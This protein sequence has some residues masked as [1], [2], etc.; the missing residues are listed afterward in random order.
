MARPRKEYDKKQFEDLVTMGFNATGVARFFHGTENEVNEWC[1]ARYGQTFDELCKEV[2]YATRPNQDK[3]RPYT[4]YM[5]I[6]PN[7]K[8]YIGITRQTLKRRWSNGHG[9]WSNDHFTSAI[10][11][12]GWNNIE[13][14][15]LYMRLTKEEAEKTEVELIK[16]F[17]TT[18]RRYGYNKEGGGS[19]NKEVSA[20]TREKL[21]EKSTGV[22]ASEE[23]RRK[24]SESH[25]GEK[26]H[27]YGVP[28]TEEMKEHLRELRS[29][30]VVQMD[31][32]GNIIS[33]FRSM[34][35]AA[36]A[37][38]VTRQAISS[39]CHGKTKKCVGYV[40]R[41]SNGKTTD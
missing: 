16:A 4:V 8:K 38:G 41:W 1:M 30:G 33:T 20:E 25:R 9:Y 19:L 15:I 23:T 10:S 3:E 6:A 17:N 26:C 35:D 13:H 39:C 14:A 32:N 22:K 27:F 21:R 18:D 37:F 28:V 29:K 36:E 11:K 34:K 2:D 24:M 40:W 31:D 12:Y 5:H 7:G